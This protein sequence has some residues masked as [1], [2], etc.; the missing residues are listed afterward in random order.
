[1]FLVINWSFESEA[2]I[3]T[4]ISTLLFAKIPNTVVESE[5]TFCVF[6]RLFIKTVLLWEKTFE[7]FIQS[8]FLT[9]A[10]A[11]LTGYDR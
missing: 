2:I 4:E 6:T 5:E 11:I 3:W 7:L 10:S 8:T 1:M 9:V